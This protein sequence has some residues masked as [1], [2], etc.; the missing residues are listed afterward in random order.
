MRASFQGIDDGRDVAM[1]PGEGACNSRAFLSPAQAAQI[2]RGTMTA[3]ACETDELARRFGERTLPKAE[4]THGAHIRVGLWHLLKHGE[5][6][7]LGLL[8]EGIKKYNLSVGGENTDTGGY[9]ETITRFYV[10]LIARFLENEDRTLPIDE[11][12]HLL[13]AR[14]GAKDVPL[15]YFSKERLMSVEAR[16]AWIEPD[17]RP[18]ALETFA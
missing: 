6:P 7:S 9:H 1:K 8:R 10:W 5:E 18:L 11:L 16:R 2:R 17:L 4:W 15:R 13:L 14:Y 12:A 3:A